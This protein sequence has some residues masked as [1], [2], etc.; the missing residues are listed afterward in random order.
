LDGRPILVEFEKDIL[1]YYLQSDEAIQ[2]ATA[3]CILHKWLERAGYRWGM[4]YGFV[5]WMH[6]EWQIECKAEIAEH[7]ARLS[8]RA[9]AWAGEYYG[10]QCPHEGESKIGINWKETH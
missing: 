2:M 5:I 8:D 10:I 1:V 4:D 9:I 3:Y 7:V 6:D